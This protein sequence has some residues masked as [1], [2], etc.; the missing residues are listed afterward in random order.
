MDTKL[1]VIVLPV[2]D[3]DRSV[4][5]YKGLGWRL[6]ADFTADDLRVVQVTPP[7]SPASVI[8]GTSLTRAQPGSADGM[9]LVVTDLQAAR[10]ELIEHGAAVSEIFTDAGGVFHHG[11]DVKRVPVPDENRTSYG[12]FATFD[13]PDG[14]TWYLQQ[15]TT[16][17][18]GRI[19]TSA[20]TF[21][22][23]QDLAEGLRRAAAAHGEHE[24]RTGAADPDWPAWYATYLV[25]E[26]H[27]TELP[28]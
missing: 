22:S 8:F 15:V 20:T 1:E 7:G 11:G 14:N 6:D 5:F 3:V 12:A 21:A 9:M 27:G 13:D 26:Q 23:P 19:D 24:A 10:A 2:S 4:M 16:R 18:P 28:S 25:S 17:L